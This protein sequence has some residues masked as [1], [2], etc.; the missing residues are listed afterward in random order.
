VLAELA[1]GR[2]RVKIPALRAALEGRFDDEHAIVIG[3]I[4][5][6]LDFLDEQIVALSEEAALAN[7]RTKDVYD[8]GPCF[9]SDHSQAEIDFFGIARSPT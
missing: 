5:A 2:L 8:A 1:Q 9:R 3:A 6:H 4:L 7:V